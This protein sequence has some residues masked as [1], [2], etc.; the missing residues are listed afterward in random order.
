[1]LKYG[2]QDLENHFKGVVAFFGIHDFENASE[3]L[4]LVFHHYLTNLRN[5]DF[6][7]QCLVHAFI[8]GVCFDFD[9]VFHFEGGMN[10]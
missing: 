10:E 3:N 9:R 8:S 2:F 7:G 1:L 5:N 6:F 4:K